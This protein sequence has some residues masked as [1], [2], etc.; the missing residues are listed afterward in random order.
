MSDNLEEEDRKKIMD[1]VDKK[2][3]RQYRVWKRLHNSALNDQETEWMNDA[4]GY[5]WAT[6][7]GY[8]TEYD[9]DNEPIKF[10]KLTLTEAERNEILGR[11]TPPAKSSSSVQ[12]PLLQRQ[13][14]RDKGGKFISPGYVRPPRPFKPRGKDG[15]Y[16]SKD[17]FLKLPQE[18]RQ[19]IVK[20]AYLKT[21]PVTKQRQ[22]ELE[23]LDVDIQNGGSSTTPGTQAKRPNTVEE[24][25]ARNRLEQK[26]SQQRRVVDDLEREVKKLE[27]V[28][29]KERKKG[30]SSSTGTTPAENN[31][32]NA[33]RRL[34]AAT[35]ELNNL[36][37]KLVNDFM[38]KN[39]NSESDIENSG[40][41]NDYDDDDDDD[42][43]DGATYTPNT[44]EEAEAITYNKDFTTMY[45]INQVSRRPVRLKTI[46]K[47][48]R[49]FAQWRF[50]D[51]LIRLYNRDL[52][53]RPDSDYS[54][55]LSI[56]SR[57][58]LTKIK[59]SAASRPIFNNQGTVQYAEQPNNTYI[60]EDVHML[61]ERIDFPPAAYSLKPAFLTLKTNRNG[62]EVSEVQ[63]FNFPNNIRPIIGQASALTDTNV[64]LIKN[65][66]GKMPTVYGSGIDPD[67]QDWNWDLVKYQIPRHT[68]FELVCLMKMYKRKKA[69]YIS[70]YNPK[71]A[72]DIVKHLLSFDFLVNR[73][74]YKPWFDYEQDRVN[75]LIGK[76][77]TVLKQA[78]YRT[79]WALE[80]DED[81]LDGD[82][83]IEIENL[84]SYQKNRR[85]WRP[86]ALGA[87]NTI[88]RG[89][90]DDAKRIMQRR[91]EV[92]IRE[93]GT[94]GSNDGLEVLE[95]IAKKTTV[96]RPRN[97]FQLER[98]D[99]VFSQP[100]ISRFVRDLENEINRP[101]G[102][103]AQADV[104]VS[105][106]PEQIATDMYTA[107]FTQKLKGLKKGYI[108]R[109]NN[110]MFHVRWD[111]PTEVFDG[112][113][114][115]TSTSDL[116]RDQLE[117]N[118]CRAAAFILSKVVDV[119]QPIIIGEKKLVDI[120]RSGRPP[121]IPI[122][123]LETMMLN[124]LQGNTVVIE[125][126]ATK[127]VDNTLIDRGD[128]NYQP[129]IPVYDLMD[130]YINDFL[131]RCELIRTDR[132][133]NGNYQD[134][135]YD[136]NGN[137]TGTDDP[138][139]ADYTP[140]EE[141]GAQEFNIATEIQNVLKDIE[142]D[143]FTVNKETADKCVQANCT[144]QSHWQQTY[145][146]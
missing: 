123:T 110:D 55:L 68:L 61:T 54:A 51:G 142:E 25:A 127:E 59:D 1:S 23:Q 130:A 93:W 15:K 121:V 10:E 53:Q 140:I 42:D 125:I 31:F 32:N 118:H 128:G 109:I 74:V 11:P 36:E 78:I 40:I 85:K 82:T 133:C 101:N 75:T 35:E 98:I 5:Q 52:K 120:L 131:V 22:K 97:L 30:T 37:Q 95:E 29:T 87:T 83:P 26:I 96:E 141:R 84:D 9:D 6:E 4:T 39:R 132:P 89:I 21:R 27:T 119:K 24:E 88:R 90:Y 122:D 47:W 146:S 13:T 129:T 81:R 106:Q 45:E 116:S 20:K 7:K 2:W 57:L 66:F 46:M 138:T 33:R 144:F 44:T 16:V 43:D 126:D 62:S 104:T 64:I 124:S 94:V 139:N 8:A 77:K 86:A 12:S 71:Y 91:Y 3:K 41:Y 70:H 34:T 107:L 17:E 115:L 112:E 103:A 28:V 111:V 56:V 135:R 38:N 50:C 19:L 102:V 117:T 72:V 143:L 18:V 69:T 73:C 49:T 48:I 79:V 60:P 80:I 92:F 65:A 108:S 63:F 134:E 145:L 76:P 99:V 114:N 100:N 137:W 67:T 113:A 14:S 136:K 105:M 58:T